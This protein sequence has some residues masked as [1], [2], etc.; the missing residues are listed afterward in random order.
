[1]DETIKAIIGG[2]IRTA[3]AGAL[4]W[5]VA[6][7]YITESQAAQ[8]PM[9][10]AGFIIVGGLSAWNKWKTG[11]AIKTALSLPSG[12]TE[13][14]LKEAIKAEDALPAGVKP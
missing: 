3:L 7:G 12:S 8:I 11:K 1:M 6:K 2:L 10:L 5:L 4:T 13:A 9:Y 14:D